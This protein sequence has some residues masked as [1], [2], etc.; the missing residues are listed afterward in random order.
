MKKIYSL[1]LSLFLT[2]VLVSQI[3][4][5]AAWYPFC[6]NGTDRSGNGR[7]ATINGCYPTTNRFGQG[8]NAY[9]FAGNGSIKI[10]TSTIMDLDSY[11]Y[12]LWI[13]I[14][15]NPA[16][17]QCIFSGGGNDIYD[18]NLLILP[19]GGLFAVSHNT[20]GSP[21]ASSV[22]SG[23][24]A[25]N[26]WHHVVVLRNSTLMQMYVDNV[27]N[28]GTYHN[29]TYSQWGT[30]SPY[31]IM[32][33]VRS[34]GL[35]HFIGQLDDVRLYGGNLNATQVKALYQEAVFPKVIAYGDSIC[36][37]ESATIMAS[38]ATSFTLP[39]TPA[40][41]V[42]PANTTTYA[43]IGSSLGCLATAT[44]E[45]VVD[46]CTALKNISEEYEMKIYPNPTNGIFMVSGNFSDNKIIRYT[47]ED[48]SGRRVLQGESF[49]KNEMEIKTDASPG[50]YILRMYADER[51]MTSKKMIITP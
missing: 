20:G 5:A 46:L 39:G 50:T 29:G 23:T 2:N 17:T 6:G 49:G 35:D 27:L 11:S 1:L 25:L 47:L 10:P 8:D 7:N 3:P 48:L 13:M 14:A 38:G 31:T 42:S 24:L 28:T 32:L 37:G 33:G 34:N 21:S 45:V 15:S 41:V 4:A 18:Q 36:Q 40:G 26:K 16:T 12:S 51:F 22:S 19:S 44:T 9:N 30:T 43:V